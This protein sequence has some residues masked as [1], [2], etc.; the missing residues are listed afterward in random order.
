MRKYSVF[1]SIF[2]G[3]FSQIF[4]S[5][6]KFHYLN[7]FTTHAITSAASDLKMELM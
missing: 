6:I 1:Y 4:I 3:L 5:I 7:R 2:N